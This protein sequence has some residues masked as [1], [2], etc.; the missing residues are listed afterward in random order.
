[1]TTPPFAAELAENANSYTPVGPA[2]I[3]IETSRYILWIGPGKA[4][5]WNVAQRLRLKAEE[6][7]ATVEEVHG[8]LRERDRDACTW[9]IGS[10]ATPGDL[11]ERL[12]ALG[13]KPDA[14]PYAVAMLLDTEPP[15][16]PPGIEV[17]PI[18]TFEDYVAAREIQARAFGSTEEHAEEERE[19]YKQAWAEFDPTRGQPFVALLDGEV[20][21][22]ATSSFTPWGVS[23]FGVATAPEARGRGAYRAL[24]RA[25]WDEAVRR[26]T[27]VL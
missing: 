3:R 1:M 12:L 9:E 17:R 25:R 14:E 15:P 19:R 23:L 2:E 7:E 18:E 24:V 16:V 8:L 5:S 13:M 10:S 4:P 21:A 20:V 6:I 11:R 22:A 26:G 27:P